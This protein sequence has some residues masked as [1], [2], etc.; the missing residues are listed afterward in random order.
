MGILR[1]L[2][3]L[4]EPL[5]LDE[6]FVD[7]A[8][9]DPAGRAHPRRV[10]RPWS[11]TSRRRGRP[12]TGGLTASVGV[13]TSKF[14]AKVASE[15]AKPDGLRVVEPGTEVDLLGPM[16]VSVIPGVG[17][18]TTEK[19]QRIGIRTV[20]DL[21]GVALDELAQTVGR[22]HA[23]ALVELAYARDDRPV[24]PERETKSI[25]V[26]DTFEIDLVDPSRAARDPRSATPARSPP[27]WAR[28]DCSPGR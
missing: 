17:P 14:I 24:E 15:L 12:A 10:S 1:D 4:V 7:L 6:A 28:P 18:V 22:A 13:G 8:R 11:P 20:A 16:P 19:L 2:S 23:Q 21:Q 27:G 9:G 25:S 5:S 3:P 26:E